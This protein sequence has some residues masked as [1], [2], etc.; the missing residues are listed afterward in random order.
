[1]AICSAAGTGGGELNILLLTQFFGFTAAE[2]A[3]LSGV[4]ILV[5]AICRFTIN[6]RQKHP[7]KNKVA[8]DYEVVLAMF[9]CVLIGTNLGVILNH[10]LSPGVSLCLLTLLLIFVFIKTI[11]KGI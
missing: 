1:M 7:F 5:S 11:K 8:P 4:F 10:T 6:F 2:S 9:P 3:P